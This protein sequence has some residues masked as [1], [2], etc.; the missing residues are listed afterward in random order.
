MPRWSERRT[1]VETP[2][3]FAE[4]S[5]R[6]SHGSEL[7]FGRYGAAGGRPVF[8]FH[9]TPG[10]RHQ[11]PLDAPSAADSE[12]VSPAHTTKATDADSAPA[13]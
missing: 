1:R 11:L 4:G 10:G 9:G 8:W 5:L 13:T 12:P 3:P 2:R 6:L 7:G